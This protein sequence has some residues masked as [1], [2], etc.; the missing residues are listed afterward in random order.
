MESHVE[1]T[2]AGRG[3]SGRRIDP[4]NQVSIGKMPRFSA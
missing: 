1:V 4:V 2:W 3:T